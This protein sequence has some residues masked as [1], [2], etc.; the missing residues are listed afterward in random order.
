[1]CYTVIGTR[2]DMVEFFCGGFEQVYAGGREEVIA[3]GRFLFGG[4]VVFGT[5]R[6]DVGWW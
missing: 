6:E 2:E 1:M 4:E 5:E 3:A